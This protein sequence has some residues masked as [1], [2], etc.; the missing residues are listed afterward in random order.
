MRYEIR[1]NGIL[2]ARSHGPQD[3]Q[4]SG[5]DSPF[6]AGMAPIYRVSLAYLAYFAAVGSASPY[7]FLYY[8]HLGLGLSEIGA[9]ASLPSDPQQ[10]P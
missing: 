5:P 10:V 2:S 1:R 9:L 7:L 6:D 8:R 3:V 4:D